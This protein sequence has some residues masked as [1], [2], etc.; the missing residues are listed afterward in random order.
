[1][2]MR[3]ILPKLHPGETM[4]QYEKKQIR[5]KLRWKRDIEAERKHGGQTF[6]TGL[7]IPGVKSEEDKIRE[8]AD[9]IYNERHRRTRISRVKD[10][11]L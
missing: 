5:R 10:L 3:D 4:E 9:R 2:S 11:D 7:L 8:E 1:M 6:K